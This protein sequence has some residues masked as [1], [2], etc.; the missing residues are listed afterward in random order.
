M[1]RVRLRAST[2][3]CVKISVRVRA[4]IKIRVRAGIKVRVRTGIKVRVRAGIRVEV[5]DRV[6]VKQSHDQSLVGIRAWTRNKS[7]SRKL[8][9]LGPVM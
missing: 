9:G 4:G 8:S 6:G 2:V 1:D 3:I 5:R 7:K